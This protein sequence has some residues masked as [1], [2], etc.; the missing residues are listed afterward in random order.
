MPTSF[1]VKMWGWT[2]TGA[3][4]IIAPGEVTPAPFSHPLLMTHRPM[5]PA[6]TALLNRAYG[7]LLGWAMRVTRP[8]ADGW[9]AA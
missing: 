8:A 4:V 1:A 2:R 5:R 7:D 9:E 3:R 6:D